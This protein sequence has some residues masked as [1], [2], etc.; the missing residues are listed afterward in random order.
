MAPCLRL[1]GAGGKRAG[2]NG[3][4]QVQL[5]QS[6]DVRVHVE[7][8]ADY[9]PSADLL[10]GEVGLVSAR[11]D[12]AFRAAQG[13]LV[14]SVM[15]GAEEIGVETAEIAFLSKTQY[16]KDFFNSIDVDGSSEGTYISCLEEVLQSEFTCVRDYYAFRRVSHTQRLDT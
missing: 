7:I 11:E 5:A 4:R 15:F 1:Y 8:F 9:K 14:G 3:Q 10:A 13:E 6:K 2:S 16:M 12:S